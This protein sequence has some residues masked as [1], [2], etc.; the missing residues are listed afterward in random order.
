MN[1]RVAVGQ[2]KGYVGEA[3][4]T[5][6]IKAADTHGLFPFCGDARHEIAARRVNQ[7]GVITVDDGF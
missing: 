6:Q 4:I 3:A 2:L 7:A 1:V 5:E